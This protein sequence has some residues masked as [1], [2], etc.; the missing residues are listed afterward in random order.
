L[1]ND[2]FATDDSAEEL[3]DIGASTRRTLEIGIE[4]F[5]FE[6]RCP[7]YAIASEALL[8]TDLGIVEQDI[9]LTSVAKVGAV[10]HT[11]EH[12]QR[13][14]PTSLRGHEMLSLQLG[15]KDSSHLVIIEIFEEETGVDGEPPGES[16]IDVLHHLFHLLFVAK[17]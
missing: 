13:N 16:G 5:C 1:R 4:V 17:E 11:A 14:T 10:A 3:L 9:N 7:G 8:L 15:V 2:S 6:N 12:L